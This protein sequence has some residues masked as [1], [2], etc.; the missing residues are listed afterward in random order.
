[1]RR[2]RDIGHLAQIR[3]SWRPPFSGGAIFGPG[4]QLL[5]SI[6][7]SPA[8]AGRWFALWIIAL[9]NYQ[10]NGSLLGPERRLLFTC[11]F[12]P[13]AR[14]RRPSS[15]A[16]VTCVAVYIFLYGVRG[17]LGSFCRDSSACRGCCA[18][19]DASLC[20]ANLERIFLR[21]CLANAPHIYS[22]VSSLLLYVK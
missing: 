3:Q 2:T 14:N 7:C 8:E 22:V 5:R 17:E 10:H 13:G 4:R 11:Q 12:S 6:G 19:T 20:H 1:M 18:E 9:D 21:F 15:C 16:R